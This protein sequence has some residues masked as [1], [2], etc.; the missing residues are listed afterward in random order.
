MRD[1]IG[2]PHVRAQ[3]AH[4][5]FFVQGYVHAQDRLWQME[6]GRRGAYGR[7]AE[8][9]GR[10]GI[11]Q[12][13]LMRRLRL[14][15]SAR[16]DYQSFNDETRAMLDSYALGVNAFIESTPVLPVEYRLVGG[17]PERW[18]PW[19]SC[20][21]YKFKHAMMGSWAQKL[22]ERTNCAPSAPRR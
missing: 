19:D 1:T 17:T 22:G 14:G 18:Q 16:T 5:A 20:A 3:S 6:L 12:D 7:W 2:V 4:D 11:A 13:T 15:A 8:Y 10:T 21:L 9:V